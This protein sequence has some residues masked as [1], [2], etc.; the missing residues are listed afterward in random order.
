M[1]KPSQKSRLSNVGSEKQPRLSLQNQNEK[2]SNP[3]IGGK[4][5]FDYPLD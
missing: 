1:S 4:D 5:K 3:N 2:K